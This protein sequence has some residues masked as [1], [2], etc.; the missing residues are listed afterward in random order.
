MT[1]SK[2][3]RLCAM[4]LIP[5]GLAN[6]YVGIWGEMWHDP[7]FAPYLGYLQWY[8]LRP[9]LLLTGLVAILIAAWY[10]MPAAWRWLIEDEFARAKE[11]EALDAMYGHFY[12]E[13]AKVEGVRYVRARP[14]NRL[15]R[16]IS[17]LWFMRGCFVGRHPA[18]ALWYSDGGEDGPRG[19]SCGI[20]GKCIS[21]DDVTTKLKPTPDLPTQRD[22]YFNAMFGTAAPPERL[23]EEPQPDPFRPWPPRCDKEG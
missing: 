9:A 19:T 3:M 5:L 17:G 12:E 7:D 23:T 18:D 13:D 4:P 21:I 6:L 15:F 1:N 2:F 22:V 8:V 14:R 16:V 11:E 20:C 10:V